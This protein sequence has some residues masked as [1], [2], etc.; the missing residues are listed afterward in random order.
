MYP[1]ADALLVLPEFQY[2]TAPEMLVN[3]TDGATLPTS[4]FPTT[5]PLLGLSNPIYHLHSS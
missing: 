3:F 4:V 5:P 1:V 2:P